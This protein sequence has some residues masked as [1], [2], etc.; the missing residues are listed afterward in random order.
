[1]KTHFTLSV[2]SLPFFL[3]VNTCIRGRICCL[4]FAVF[5][6]NIKVFAQPPAA[7]DS[8]PK[9][10]TWD[11]TVPLFNNIAIKSNV[12]YAKSPFNANC[13]DVSYDDDETKPGCN[14]TDDCVSG[15][16]ALF[17]DVYYPLHDYNAV[18]LPAVILGHPG[19]FE[20]CSD[21]QQNWL[22]TVCTTLAKRGYVVFNIEYRRGRVKDAVNPNYRS[23]QNLAAAYRGCQ[24]ERGVIRS[25]IKRER[26]QTEPYRIDTNKIFIGGASA[27]AVMS[28]NAAW[29]TNQMVY[30][31]FPTPAGFPTVDQVL[32]PIDADFYF[33]ETDI[34]FKQKIKGV[35]FLWGGFPIPYSYK[36]NEQGFFTNATLK[37]FIAFHGLDDPVFPY[38]LNDPRHEETFSIPPNPGG[39][40]YNRETRCLISS[41]YKIDIDAN[42]KDMLN[43][44]PLNAYNILTAVAP[45]IPKELYLDCNMMHGLDMNGP[46][47]DSEFGT[48]Y[49]N[50]TQVSAYIAQRIATFFQAVMNGA[51]AGSINPSKFT[52]CENKRKKCDPPPLPL[53]DNN[54]ICPNE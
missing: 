29:Y 26:L 17:Y 24:D 9:K 8:T 23:V 7:S 27:G 15:E 30:D 44:G 18:K 54:T 21:L 52:E 45:T 6:F 39:F 36:G 19:G 32:D 16:A 48:G 22:V 33:G 42:T 12:S 31:A 50:T 49:T 13:K 14:P 28:F 47:F 35:A 25:I 20:E 3:F 10:C 5:I 2:F 38:R 46:G 4:L 43:A 41:P 51:T 1:M 40:N 37:P 34:E 53:C 11:L